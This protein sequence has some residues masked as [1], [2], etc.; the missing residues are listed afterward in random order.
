MNKLSYLI[1]GICLAIQSFA[2]STDIDTSFP[3]PLNHINLNP[4][5]IL[6][7]DEG[8]ENMDFEYRDHGSDQM[9]GDVEFS[10][11]SP[12]TKLPSDVTLDLL[13]IQLSQY[14]LGQIDTIPAFD[15]LEQNEEED[16]DTPMPKNRIVDLSRINVK[17]IE[18]IKVVADTTVIIEHNSLDIPDQS[19]PYISTM[20]ITIIDQRLC[21]LDF[22]C[23]AEEYEHCASFFEETLSNLYTEGYQVPIEILEISLTHSGN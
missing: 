3:S 20:Y 9:R 18:W 17:G 12:K 6:Y 23:A 14:N 15:L 21:M 1:F 19:L 22:S 5:W 16:G 7:G 11:S 13:D 8:A 10:I 2:N 4:G